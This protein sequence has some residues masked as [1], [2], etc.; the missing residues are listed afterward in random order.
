MF[1]THK[2][3]L[4]SRR[5]EAVSA[6]WCAFSCVSAIVSGYALTPSAR[7]PQLGNQEDTT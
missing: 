4:S 6:T 3:M 1:R 2:E 5:P 7:K